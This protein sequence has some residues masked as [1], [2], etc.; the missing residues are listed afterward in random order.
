MSVV[1]H[2][3]Q[4]LVHH[5]FGH[6]PV[7]RERRDDLAQREGEYGRIGSR[8]VLPEVIECAL[9]NAAA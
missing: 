1:E 5:R 9:G 3:L 6:R 7:F 2:E 8:E 4:V